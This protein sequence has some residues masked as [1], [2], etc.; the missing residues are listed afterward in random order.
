[1]KA[2]KIIIT[3]ILSI[4]ILGLTG[5]L[6]EHEKPSTNI[7]P[8]IPGGEL[9]THKEMRE[10]PD[11]V[12]EAFNAIGIDVGVFAMID[13]LN[14]DT[15]IFKGKDIETEERVLEFPLTTMSITPMAVIRH[16]GS[17]CSTIIV[18]GSAAGGCSH[19]SVR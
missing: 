8:Y 7:P 17:K 4:S 5:C 16:E 19:F 11:G 2:K 13:H 18:G 1:M 15:F 12:E 14:G 10:L 3:T 6:K 9:P